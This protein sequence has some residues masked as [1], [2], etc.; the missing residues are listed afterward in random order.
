M[1]ENV[2]I[3]DVELL[4]V[5]RQSRIIKELCIYN[6]PK[7]QL[8]TFMVL[9]SVPRRS[10]SQEIQS[11]NSYITSNIHKI[12]YNS[13]NI[14]ETSAVAVLYRTTKHQHVFAKGYDKCRF[15]ATLLGKCVYNLETFECPKVS[16]LPSTND[17]SCL[18][19]PTNFLHC[20]QI[21]FLR[22][23]CWFYPVLEKYT[24]VT[25]FTGCEEWFT[26]L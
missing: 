19:H 6:V 21:N 22:L 15:I 11:I 12:D 14:D 18:Y 7:K 3:V 4:H 8:Q 26:L 2:C 9:P 25:E 16:D 24:S 23:G 17:C 20:C 10:L 5:T 1:L 13:G